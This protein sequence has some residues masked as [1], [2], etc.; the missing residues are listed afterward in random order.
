MQ[1]AENGAHVDPLFR[2]R[3]Q[4]ISALVCRGAVAI[5]SVRK[6]LLIAAYSFGSWKSYV[7]N[8]PDGHLDFNWYLYFYFISLSF[9]F[10]AY[11]EGKQKLRKL[12]KIGVRFQFR[13]AELLFVPLPLSIALAI[14][15]KF[16]GQDLHILGLVLINMVMGM[17]FGWLDA[18]DRW[19]QGK[20]VNEQPSLWYSACAMTLRSLLWCFTIFILTFLW[21]PL[22]F[23]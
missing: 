14:T 8:A 19:Y 4:T 12:R 7:M 1:G 20:R 2:Q 15:E 21:I 6:G 16:G 9:G 18:R 17:A 3:G 23:R 5:V 10:F 13:L 11:F 22:L